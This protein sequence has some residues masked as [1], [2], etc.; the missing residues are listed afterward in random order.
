MTAVM[1]FFD[2]MEISGP[3]WVVFFW[4]FLFFWF[5]I[6]HNPQPSLLLTIEIHHIPFIP[7][8]ITLLAGTLLS[9]PRST[10]FA[11]SLFLFLFLSRVPSIPVPRP[12][13][14]R[15][16]PLWSLSFPPS[17]CKSSQYL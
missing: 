5:T 4:F 1:I 15:L 11:P 7:L 17:L 10:L 6:N 14:L 12:S 3:G 8:I 13:P 16:R 9:T 2:M